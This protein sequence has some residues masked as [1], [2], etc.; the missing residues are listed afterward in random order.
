M[1]PFKFLFLI[2]ISV[3]FVISCT[4]TNNNNS[5][6]PTPLPTDN[7][8]VASV[9]LISN[10]NLLELSTDSFLVTIKSNNPASVFT[11]TPNKNLR[12]TNNVQVNPTNPL[13]N[14]AYRS[15]KLYYTPSVGEGANNGKSTTFSFNFANQFGIT[16]SISLNISIYTLFIANIKP[17]STRNNPN[18]LLL[19]QPNV[20]NLDIT[21]GATKRYTFVTTML[22]NDSL[23]FNSKTYRQNDT[24]I[25]NQSTPFYSYRLI[26]TPRA[27]FNATNPGLLALRVD[28]MSIPPTTTPSTVA[29]TDTIYFTS[30]PVVLRTPASNAL[31]Q[32]VQP[33]FSWGFNYPISGTL[34]Y[35]LYWG[36]NPAKWG[37]MANTS[38]TSITN[39]NV[40]NNNQK[41]YWYVVAMDANGNLVSRSN[42]D[43]FTTGGVSLPISASNFSSVALNGKIYYCGAVTDAL[44]YVPTD[45]LYIYDIASSTWTQSPIPGGSRWG[46]AMSV[47]NNNIY[48]I[49]GASGSSSLQRV[50]IYNTQTSTWKQGSNIP[51]VGRYNMGVATIGTN[52]YVFGGRNISPGFVNYF[53]Q[54]DLYNTNTNTWTTNVTQIPNAPNHSMGV[55]AIGNRIYLI[56]G[57]DNNSGSTNIVNI[58]DV[59][60]G[61]NWSL[62]APAPSTLVYNTATVIGNNIYTGYSYASI[63]PSFVYLPNVFYIYN[64]TNN[65]WSQTPQNRGFSVVNSS[66]SSVD[67]KIYVAGGFNNGLNLPETNTFY[68]FNTSTNLWEY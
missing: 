63:Y 8:F 29:I 49:G 47:A 17:F 2:S 11:I 36:T 46:V 1:H 22:S 45:Q 61:Y 52:I 31:N 35:A 48:I 7:N 38:N 59:T 9:S 56:G 16:Q 4:K 27:T 15:F 43:S 18:F 42:I 33:T 5:T 30:E 66:L 41:Y 57:A 24:L 21:Q 55:A 60:N 64:T 10:K 65:S 12:D 20:L 39:L 32:F 3:L 50:D 37:N 28:T 23:V 13:K 14:I 58:L 53:N 62:G 25:F 26:Y 40:L 44:N 68:I 34:N 67:N 51:T 54:V 6:P 19:D